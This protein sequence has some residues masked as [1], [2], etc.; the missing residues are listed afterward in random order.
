[1]GRLRAHEVA[2][3]CLTLID[4]IVAG[5]SQRNDDLATGISGEGAHRSSFR[6]HNLKASTHQ[7][8]GGAFLILQDFQRSLGRLLLNIVGVIA[9]CR[10]TQSGRRVRIAHIVLQVAVLIDLGTYCIIDCVLIHIRAERKLDAA[11]L[12]GHGIR[13]IQHL[14]FA[15]IA[16][17]GRFRGD[18]ADLLVV[19]VDDLGASGHS[20][21]I[22][23]GDIDAIIAHPGLRSDG[24]HLLEVFLTIDCDGICYCLIRFRHQVGGQMRAPGSATAIDVFCDCQDLIGTLQFHASE[25]GIDLQIVNVPVA[26]QITPERH[27]RGV[28]SLIFVFKLQF[29]EATLRIAV[30]DDA[31]DF[32]I[33]ADL[34]G[35][36][37]DAL[38]LGY[39]LRHPGNVGIDTICRNLFGVAVAIH[40]VVVGVN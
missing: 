22:S 1:M 39:R 17:A 13:R 23:E 15:G 6:V 12:P 38:T 21:G 26:E 8:N 28:V 31:D 25:A 32:R 40:I 35:E 30:C 4:S 2:S 29:T 36:I 27:F 37:L 5:E 19:H 34:L 24:E 20:R 7:R 33:A 11:S 3:G 10:E 9:V 14:E 18:D 16:T